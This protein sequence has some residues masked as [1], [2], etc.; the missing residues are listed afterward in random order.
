MTLG[1]LIPLIFLFVACAEVPL[2]LRWYSDG[3][4]KA[5]VAFAAMGL[6]LA[7]PIAAYAVLT[8]VM[9]DLGATEVL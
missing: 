4:M 2:F 3:R 1:A 6:S 8:F 5:G 7:L 9:P